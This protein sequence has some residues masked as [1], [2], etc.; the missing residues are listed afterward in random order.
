MFEG[1]DAALN[2]VEE[3]EFRRRITADFGKERA[4]GEKYFYGFHVLEGAAENAFRWM[5]D[6]DA[7]VYLKSG[8][9]PVFLEFAYMYALEDKPPVQIKLNGVLLKT[10]Y[11]GCGKLYEKIAIPHDME[12]RTVWEVHFAMESLWSPKTMINSEDPRNLGIA[13]FQDIAVT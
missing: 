6:K 13:V 3:K 2:S 7:Y 11:A 4:W 8:E 10:I 9:M 5:S 1:L 12:K